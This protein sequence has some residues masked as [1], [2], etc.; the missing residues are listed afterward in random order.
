V[1][2]SRCASDSV[3]TCCAFSP[4]QSIH[5]LLRNAE[6]AH[7]FGGFCFSDPENVRAAL[8]RPGQVT[9]AIRQCCTFVDEQSIHRLLAKHAHFWG[10]FCFS[11]PRTFERRFAA[12]LCHIALCGTA[13]PLLTSNQ[14]IGCSQ[15]TR[16][17]LGVSVFPI[18]RTFGRRCFGQ[19]KSHPLYDSAAPSLM[20]NQIIGCS[21]TPKNAQ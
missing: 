7:F 19:A 5:R 20:N 16:I 2:G 1:A 21:A 10:V 12:R 6:N 17:F 13:A 18:P 14:F 3:A 8:F 4:E 9:S 11:D 15:N